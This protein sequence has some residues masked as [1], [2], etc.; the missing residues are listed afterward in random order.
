LKAGERV[1]VEG[2]MKIRDGSRVKPVPASRAS[3]GG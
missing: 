2:Q 1:V 3:A